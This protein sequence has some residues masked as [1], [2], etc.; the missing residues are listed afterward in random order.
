MTGTT[1]Y[2]EDGRP[3]VRIERALRHPVAK[4]WRAL[5]EPSQLNQW[6]PFDYHDNKFPLVH[7]IAP[8]AVREWITW[9]VRGK[10]YP[11]SEYLSLPGLERLIRE[12]PG[13]TRIVCS[14]APRVS[15]Q[16]SSV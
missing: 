13:V 3:A 9:K 16:A 4:V 14:L 6:F 1:R 12:S 2:T 10:R 11:P 5:T 15:C 7:W 8:R